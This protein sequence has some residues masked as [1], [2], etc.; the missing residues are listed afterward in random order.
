MSETSDTIKH[1]TS[2]KG[3]AA[4]HC[5]AIP[6]VITVHRHSV[7]QPIKHRTISPDLKLLKNAV[8]LN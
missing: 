4:V 7:K 8:K 2:L 6:S 3:V 1:F 5:E